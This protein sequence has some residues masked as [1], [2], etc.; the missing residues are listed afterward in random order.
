[1]IP[2]DQAKSPVIQG[3]GRRKVDE[4]SYRLIVRVLVFERV[5]AEADR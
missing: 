3:L 1:M 4:I 5:V 2:S